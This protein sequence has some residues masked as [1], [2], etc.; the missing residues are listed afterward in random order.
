MRKFFMVL[1]L[2][3]LENIDTPFSI[4][5]C[6]IFYC[7]D[8]TYYNQLVLSM[9]IYGIYEIMDDWQIYLPSVK[10]MPL[11]SYIDCYIRLIIL[12]IACW[13]ISSWYAR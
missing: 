8:I 9:L 4:Y 5:W 12:Q 2:G 1:E 6:K 3:Q 11:K 7:E 10:A 13:M